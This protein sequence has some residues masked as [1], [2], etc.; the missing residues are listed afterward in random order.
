[1]YAPK[2]LSLVVIVSTIVMLVWCSSVFAQACAV[3][4]GDVDC[5]GSVTSSDVLCVLQK[6]LGQPSCLDD[7]TRPTVDLTG[8]W[9]GIWV[10]GGNGGELTV[11]FSQGE[12]T[13]SGDVSITNSIC[14]TRDSVSGTIHS[15]TILFGSSSSSQHQSKFDGTIDQFGDTIRGH[16]VVTGGPCAGSAGEWSLVR[17]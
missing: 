12:G 2:R 8:S 17:N 14:T 15:N 4:P 9:Q 7:G 3:V 1:M 13:L 16:F 10:G 6:T 11:N 5:D